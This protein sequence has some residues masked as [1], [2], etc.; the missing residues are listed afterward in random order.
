MRPRE[1][2]LVE[3]LREIVEFVHELGLD[4]AIVENGDCTGREDA[5]RIRELTGVFLSRKFC[6]MFIY[7]SIV[8]AQTRS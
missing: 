3:R 6:C 7:I 5:R 4:V 8:Q 2:A 1:R